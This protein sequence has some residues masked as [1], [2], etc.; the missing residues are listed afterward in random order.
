MH[1]ANRVSQH[2]RLLGPI[3]INTRACFRSDV[4]AVRPSQ[5]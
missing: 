5:Y 2:D 4:V 3:E 1:V